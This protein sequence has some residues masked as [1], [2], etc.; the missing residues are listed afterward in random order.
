M[1][2]V[3]QKEMKPF[4][5]DFIWDYCQMVTTGLIPFPLISKLSVLPASHPYYSSNFRAVIVNL[6]WGE[7]EES[8][9]FV[10]MCRRHTARQ[11]SCTYFFVAETECLSI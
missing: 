8:C 5:F 10:F 4:E 6:V 2:M 7:W 1:E 11:A 9:S 3:V